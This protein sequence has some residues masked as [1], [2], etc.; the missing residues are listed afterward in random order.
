MG[1]HPLAVEH[2]PRHDLDHSG[3][4]HFVH[5]RTGTCVPSDRLGLRLRAV[6][7]NPEAVDTAGV[8]VAWLRYR[9]VLIA[10]GRDFGSVHHHVPLCK[11]KING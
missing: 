9:A 10:G 8:S 5:W 2:R 1:D 4:C 7:E 11:G 6:G 3:I